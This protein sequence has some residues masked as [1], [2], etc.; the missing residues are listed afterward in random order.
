MSPSLRAWA[1]AVNLVATLV[2]L[3]PGVSALRREKWDSFPLTTYPMFSQPRPETETVRYV[4]GVNAGGERVLVPS[5]YWTAGGFNQ[6]SMQLGAIER[7][8]KPALKDLCTQIAKRVEGRHEARLAGVV[9]VVV[10]RG[11]YAPN[12]VF[13]DGDPT[14]VREVVL[15]RCPVP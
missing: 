4:F 2:V 10:A 15:A 11:R 5:H 1:I 14:P 6:G 12:Q 7:R 9:E 3:A 8:G 13:R